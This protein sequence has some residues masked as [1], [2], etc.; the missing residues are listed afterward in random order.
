VCVCVCVCVCL[1]MALC[2]LGP[3][4]ACLL[5]VGEAMVWAGR[6]LCVC[7]CVSECVLGPMWE[8]A[9]DGGPY[10]QWAHTGRETKRMT[11]NVE[12]VRTR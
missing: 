1:C 7:V 12:M 2:A 10:G 5:G 4:C 8:K 9:H 6:S 3:L 11:K